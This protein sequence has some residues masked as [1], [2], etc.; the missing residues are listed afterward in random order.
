MPAKPILDGVQLQQVEQ[1]EGDQNQ[2]QKQHRVAALEGDF[3]QPLGRRAARIRLRGVLTGPQSRKSLE[4][5]RAK[6]RLAQPVSF[7]SDIAAATK[8]GRVLIEHMEIKERAGKPERFEY[9]ITL[10]EYIG[11]SGAKAVAPPPA[12]APPAPAQL[13]RLAVEVTAENK[14]AFDA[15]SLKIR[16]EGARQ[17]GG[18]FSK[19]L[20][21]RSVLAWN[22]E[23]L[24]P[25]KYLVSAVGGAPPMAG[26]AGV[27]VSAGQTSRIA[28]NLRDAAPLAPSFIV[29]FSFNK[30]F[31]EPPMK[32]VLRMVAS[33]A[34]LHP[35][36]R[37]AIAGHADLAE[38]QPKA[39]SERRWRAVFAFLTQGSN[40]A[41]KPDWEKLRKTDCW[42]RREYQWMLS[43]LGYFPFALESDPAFARSAVQAF[44]QDH[45]L[46][47]NGVVGDATWSALIEEYMRRDSIA[48]PASQILNAPPAV[49]EPADDWEAR[50]SDDPVRNTAD[51]WR[52]NRRTE[53]IFVKAGEVARGEFLVQ[54]AEAGTFLVRGAVHLED[55]TPLRH[56]KYVLTAPDGESMD[57][58]RPRGPRKG[59]PV[60]GKTAADGSFFYPEQPKGP[61]VYTFEIQGPWM[62]RTKGQR[63]EAAK[64]PCAW[65]R[66]DGTDG[67]ELIACPR[68]ESSSLG[69]ATC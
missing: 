56:A 44:Q 50:G 16:L 29:H 21:N 69:E 68:P 30:A 35:H 20:T 40:P 27:V 5:L 48:V 46:P 37:L 67:F 2:M 61:G 31:I 66:L 55:G 12:S 39:L 18:T 36:E 58:E 1:I 26:V 52:P 32:V 3:Y 34:R 6:F 8:V 47:G 38:P 51:A 23:N 15:A 60:P 49:D 17:R 62:L 59:L 4:T 9:V 45:A 7:V 53:L 63:P 28:V 11:P 41:A 19:E 14:T 13:G 43:D 54:P 22:E 64:G 42:G 25:G 57:G 10:V 33:Y 65:T 24:V